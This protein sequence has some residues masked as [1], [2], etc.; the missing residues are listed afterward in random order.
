MSITG[1]GGAVTLTVEADLA[2]AA[3]VTSSSGGSVLS[4]SGVVAGSPYWDY[5]YFDDSGTIWQ[6]D[7]AWTDITQWVRSISTEAR[8]ERQN[9]QFN[10]GTAR[11]VLDNRDGRFSPQNTSSP[12]RLGGNTTIGIWRQIRV[13]ASY[14][15]TLGGTTTTYSWSIFSGFIRSWNEEFPEFAKDAIVSVDCVDLFAKIAAITP[16]AQTALGAGDTS[17]ARIARILN[18]ANVVAPL[19]YFD[20]GVNTMQATTLGTNAL[21][22]AKLVADSE[23][24]ALWCGPDG[25]IYFDNQ[26]ALISKAR[27]NT[28]QVTFD[29]STTTGTLAAESIETSYNGDLLMNVANY[30]RVGGTAQTVVSTNSRALYGD[31]IVTRSDLICQTDAQALTLATRDV[32]LNQSPEL[33]VEGL[34]FKPQGQNTSTQIQAAW[35][36]LSQLLIQMRSLV[37]VK[38]TPP[39]GDVL[40][41]LVHVNGISHT[42][43]PDTWTVGLQ[44][45]SA[46]VISSLFNS[47]WDAAGAQ[48]D[49]IAFSW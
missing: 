29:G 20:V 25:S 4:P 43:T 40:N 37:R 31:R 30:T 32:A 27:S 22:E 38:L 26:N 28:V 13:S 49:A 41:R 21:S 6:S 17:D 34:T 36:A 48:W 12:Y 10:A 11:I 8:F 35:L 44:F 23:G 24:G 7:V 14:A 47:N 15:Y 33:R 16:L 45:Q 1:W 46:T 5:G 2:Q 42:I 39:S 18:N 19:R 3:V 9:N